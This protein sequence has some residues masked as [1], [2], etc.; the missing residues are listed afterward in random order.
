[1]CG[2]P[3]IPSSKHYGGSRSTG[4][5]NVDPLQLIGFIDLYSAH[6]DCLYACKANGRGW[7]RP[8]IS[9]IKFNVNR[10]ENQLVLPTMGVDK[11]RRFPPQL[12]PWT[13][14][15]TFPVRL[16]REPHLRA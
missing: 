6:S 9:W 8:P 15:S 4:T 7:G 14:G 13:N 10:R 3:S 1:M 11:D 5:K 16:L 12:C 2:S